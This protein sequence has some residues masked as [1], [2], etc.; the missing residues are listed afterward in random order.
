MG[1]FRY[2]T[3]RPSRFPTFPPLPIGLSFVKRSYIRARTSQQL[4]MPPRSSKRQKTTASNTN[5]DTN[6]MNGASNGTQAH[7]WSDLPSALSSALPKANK[8][9]SNDGELKAFAT[10]NAITAPATFGVKAAGSDNA[11]II[12]VQNGK[13]DISSGTTKNCS[14]VLSALPEQWQEF[15]K[16]TPV[17]PYQSFWGML[18]SSEA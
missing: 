10:T 18:A 11:I 12:T 5:G 15:M 17:M 13:V 9:A 1:Y 3:P 6:K 7:A 14:F 16:P 4:S 2:F 8:A